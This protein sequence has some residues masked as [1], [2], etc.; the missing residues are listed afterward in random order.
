MICS[1]LKNLPVKTGISPV[2]AVVGD[3][4]GTDVVGITMHTTWEGS[5]LHVP[6]SIPLAVHTELGTDGANPD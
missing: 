3:I 1:L 4:E 5:G 2:V 6:S